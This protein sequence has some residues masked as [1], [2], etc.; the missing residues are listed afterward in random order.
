M[1]FGGYFDKNYPTQNGFIEMYGLTRT[2]SNKGYVFCPDASKIFSAKSGGVSLILSLP[3]SI[4]SGVYQPILGKNDCVIRD[5]LIWGVNVGDFYITQPGIYA[6]FTPQGIEFTIWTSAGKYSIV[7]STSTIE[8]NTDFEIDFA[9]NKNGVL[10]GYDVNMVL[11]VQ[12]Q[13]KASGKCLI[14]N[15]DFSNIG[16]FNNKQR[17]A[18]FCLLANT[19]QKTG[20]EG[21]IR[22]IETYASQETGNES[23]SSESS[24]SYNIVRSRVS[25]PFSFCGVRE[26]VVVDGKV[27][28]H[29]VIPR[30][31]FLS[32]TKEYGDF[33]SKFPIDCG[34][35][36]NTKN[37]AVPKDLPPGFEEVEAL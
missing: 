8:P 30:T 21:T 11:F 22:R 12:K 35:Y 20:I 36:D 3:Y 25:L 37:P 4:I 6:A 34:E 19:S 29:T 17:G 24:Q 31:A 9:W 7:D 27:K 23:T 1:S 10:D 2:S 26:N 33:K 15:D 13:L 16:T 5:M 14:E 18:S 28:F 32:E